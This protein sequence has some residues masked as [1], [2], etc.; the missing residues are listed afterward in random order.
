LEGPG[1]IKMSLKEEGE[2]CELNSSDP[3]QGPMAGSCEHGNV[4][5]S[6][7]KAWEIFS[8]LAE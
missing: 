8:L 2:R 4:P 3:G 7:T 1:N 6:P 5:S